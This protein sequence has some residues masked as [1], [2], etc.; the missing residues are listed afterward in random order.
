MRGLDPCIY[1]LF[2]SFCDF[3]DGGVKPGT[4]PLALFGIH[5]TGRLLLSTV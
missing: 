1:V 5:L 4:I 2:R 3:V